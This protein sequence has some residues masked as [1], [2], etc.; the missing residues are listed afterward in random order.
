MTHCDGVTPRLYLPHPATTGPPSPLLCFYRGPGARATQRVWE[1]ERLLRKSSILITHI[2]QPSLH[3][4]IK[5]YNKYYSTFPEL[6]HKFSSITTRQKSYP[7]LCPKFPVRTYTQPSLH[8]KYQDL[9]PWF[10]YMSTSYPNSCP[11][12]QSE[13]LL[14]L[15]CI[16]NIKT[17]IHDLTTCP[18]AIQTHAQIPSQNIYSTFFAY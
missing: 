14:N 13:H 6:P 4:K 12:S 11:N 18:L 2:T 8:T 10:D 7:N 3:T 17:Y 16:L 1:D 15:P 9:Y 5:T